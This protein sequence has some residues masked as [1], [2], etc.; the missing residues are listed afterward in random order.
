MELAGKQED[1]TNRQ[2]FGQG[3]RLQLLFK[4]K[5]CSHYLFETEFKC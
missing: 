5:F 3:E 4:S 1:R 2:A